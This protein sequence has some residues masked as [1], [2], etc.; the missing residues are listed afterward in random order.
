M[1]T[2]KGEFDYGVVKQVGRQ[3]LCVVKIDQV[4]IKYFYLR[5][6]YTILVTG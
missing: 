5:L 2:N 3:S 6:I 1:W 4:F